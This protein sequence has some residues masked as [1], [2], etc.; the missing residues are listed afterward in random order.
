VSIVTCPH[1]GLVFDP[2][3]LPRQPFRVVPGTRIPV[4]MDGVN[5]LYPTPSVSDPAFADKMKARDQAITDL[6]AYGA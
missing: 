4:D 6:A 5:A 3:K 1:T 2:D